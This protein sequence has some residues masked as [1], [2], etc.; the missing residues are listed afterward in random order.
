MYL[1]LKTTAAIVGSFMLGAGAI[2]TPSPSH[3]PS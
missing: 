1:N 3:Q 2:C